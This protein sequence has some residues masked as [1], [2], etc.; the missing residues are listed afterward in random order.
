LA[1]VKTGIKKRASVD[2]SLWVVNFRYT[3]KLDELWKVGSK[4]ELKID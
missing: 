3:T 4:A 1:P 2:G